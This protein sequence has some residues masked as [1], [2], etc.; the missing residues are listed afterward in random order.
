MFPR[1]VNGVKRRGAPKLETE[2]EGE[3]VLG[4]MCGSLVRDQFVLVM[5]PRALCPK[6]R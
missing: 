1:D 3:R 5:R 4:H 6:A 2:R